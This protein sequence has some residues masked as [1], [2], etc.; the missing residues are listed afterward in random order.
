MAI[1]VRSPLKSVTTT[2]V[3]APCSAE[4]KFD[5]LLFSDSRVVRQKL[6]ILVETKKILLDFFTFYL[7]FF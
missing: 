5:F 7:F 3:N 1:V 6:I 4:I 2:S